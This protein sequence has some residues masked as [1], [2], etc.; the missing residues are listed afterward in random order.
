MVNFNLKQRLKHFLPFYWAYGLLM[1]RIVESRAAI[2]SIYYSWAANRKGL[3]YS[4]PV[5][6][7][8][9]R[10]RLARRGIFPTPKE[11]L[12]IFAAVRHAN[13]EGH[14]LI[15]GLQKFGIVTH[16]DWGAKGFD[17]S[18]HDWVKRGRPE[19]NWVLL[20]AVEQAHRAR[21]IDLLF[22]YL[23][24]WQVQPETIEAIG[25]LGIVTVNMCLDDK[26]MFWGRRAQGLW[27]GLAA[28]VQSFDLH[29]T[30]T[31][32]G[33]P[34]YLARG[35]IPYFWPEGA[36]PGFHKPYDVP[37]DIRVSFV[38]QRY[39]YRPFLINH[40]RQA[41]IPVETFG[42]GWESGEMTA[43]EMVKVYSR[44]HINLGV[45]GVSYSRRMT[46]LKGRDFEIPMSG[47]LY[48]TQYNPEL[49][50]C[51]RIGEEI[52]CYHNER[53]LI[54]KIRYFLAHPEHAERIRTAG[55]ERALRDHTWEKRFKD[56]LQLIGFVQDS[57][58]PKEF[59]T[60]SMER[61]S[62]A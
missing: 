21:P 27:Y 42:L 28:L 14:S 29:C 55:R 46:C 49:E 43:E 52:V 35:G 3:V 10:E 20:E 16:F 51:Y 31:L 38:G 19:L 8:M 41:G 15:P 26:H 24:H 54:E 6:A 37:R 5:V 2:E 4:E 1:G 62:D 47:G 48:L 61:Q 7:H 30:N 33:L 11:R 13:W 57:R 40:L 34:K 17:E 60:G 44:S 32:D 56:L 23:A 58:G 53:D 12:N 22:G 9:L 36:N 18:A 50:Q 25:R 39:G 45:G 59:A